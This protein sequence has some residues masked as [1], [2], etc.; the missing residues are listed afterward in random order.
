MHGK[1]ILSASNKRE[2][3]YVVAIAD[4]DPAKNPAVICCKASSNTSGKVY[5]GEF[6]V[7][8]LVGSG[9]SKIQPNN[10]CRVPR[11]EL[12]SFRHIAKIKANDMAKFEEGL[13]LAVQTGEFDAR[14]QIEVLTSW[15]VFP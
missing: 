7:S 5:P 2:P 11:G 4:F 12:N 3:K 14:E 15:E 9:G 13:R 6:I 8:G 10:V 1:V